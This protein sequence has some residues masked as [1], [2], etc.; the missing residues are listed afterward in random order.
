MLPL[1]LADALVRKYDWS[2]ATLF[3]G[4][5]TGM[6]LSAIA[7]PLGIFLVGYLGLR[8]TILA[9]LL[10][11]L[12]TLGLSGVCTTPVQ[13]A[14]IW[15]VSGAASGCLNPLVIGSTVTASRFPSHCGAASGLFLSCALAGPLFALPLFSL[16]LENWGHMTV[17]LSASCLVIAAILIAWGLIPANSLPGED[18]SHA[19]PRLAPLFEP[20]KLKDLSLLLF[21]TSVCGVTSTGLVGSHLIS[22]C[23]VAGLDLSVGASVTAVMGLIAL[24]GGLIFGVAADRF[25]GLRLLAAYYVFRAVLL[26]WLP[27]SSFS[28]EELSHFAVL[29]GL[30]WAATMPALARVA[31][32]RFGVLQIG[33]VMSFL[34]VAHHGAAG[35]ASFLLASAGSQHFSSAFTFGSVLCLL[36]ALLL[37]IRRTG[38]LGAPSLSPCAGDT[39][40]ARQEAQS[41]NVNP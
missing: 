7:A 11:L 9:V 5:S 10:V 40:C 15:A 34:A 30:D 25:N 33:A 38:A 8:R 14:L 21:L 37:V 12:A 39:T 17:L 36:A 41:N 20:A 16:L 4:V 2:E 18:R 13:F 26:F 27:R 28:F 29:Y 3:A 31:L 35:A 23:R 32:D 19:R 1:L 24:F 22:I 6:T